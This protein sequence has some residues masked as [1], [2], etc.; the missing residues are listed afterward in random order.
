MP[1][2]RQLGKTFTAY[3][4]DT[5]VVD[6][7][8]VK[9]PQ[10]GKRGLL[11][12]NL[13]TLV[14]GH[15]LV[16]TK[17][18]KTSGCLNRTIEF[19][20][21][22]SKHNPSKKTPSKK[23]S[24]AKKKQRSTES[25][26]KYFSNAHQSK[27]TSKA[28][29]QSKDQSKANT[30]GPSLLDAI[31]E[32]G[33]AKHVVALATARE[34]E[35]HRIHGVLQT[36]MSSARKKNRLRRSMSKQTRDI[37][38]DVL[39]TSTTS[40]SNTA[41]ISTSRESEKIDHVNPANNQIVNA[42]V[43]TQYNLL[44]DSCTN[45]NHSKKR[46]L[47]DIANRLVEHSPNPHSPSFTNTICE[48]LVKNNHKN[49]KCVKTPNS[50][51]STLP[52]STLNTGTTTIAADTNTGTHTPPKSTSPS[53]KQPLPKTRGASQKKMKRKQEKSF[54]RLH[55][56]VGLRNLSRQP[57]TLQGLVLKKRRAQKLA[58]V[59]VVAENQQQQLR[60]LD[61]EQKCSEYVQEKE[62]DW[63]K[64]AQLQAENSQL[65]LNFENLG[66][67]TFKRGA[68]IADALETS[69][70]E[71]HESKS[72]LEIAKADLETSQSN[73]EDSQLELKNC[74]AELEILKAVVSRLKKEANKT[75]QKQK[76]LESANHDLAIQLD[77]AMSS[78]ARSVAAL[79]N[80]G[81]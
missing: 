28:N 32:V 65:Q 47:S 38:S 39:T 46:K 31:I 7:H 14:G 43:T 26:K 10:S 56:S 5:Y 78:L 50:A 18:K 44:T 71:L 60:L 11:E 54:Q 58:H 27:D 37:I 51:H 12:R 63:E 61:L 17:P 15:G 57:H 40:T 2:N 62:W 75:A 25:K 55:R 13:N 81:V 69:E 23:L 68:K 1:F 70:F 34:A 72:E 45:A 42:S 3:N 79:D 74:S 29:T 52:L 73:L 53:A 36:A 8:V 6:D 33:R 67:R 48:D 66:K 21:D 76:R 80:V 4:E 19:K 24:S 41:P 77:I 20:N 49:T 35:K 22:T 59:A 30:E 9:T 16:L 64:I